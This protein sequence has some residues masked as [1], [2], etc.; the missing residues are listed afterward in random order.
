MT[1]GESAPAVAESCVGLPLQSTETVTDRWPM[2]DGGPTL[3]DLVPA[4]PRQLTMTSPLLTPLQAG[5]LHLKNRVVMAP[6]TRVRAGKTHVPNALMA[7]YYAQRASAGL[8]MTE[9][10]MV[11]ADA[12]AFIAEGGIFDEATAAGWKDVADAVHARGGQIIMQIWHPGRA[13][14]SANNR[15]VQSVSATTKPIR[16]DTIQTPTGK[17]PYQAPR[18]LRTDEM[19]GIVELFRSGAERA[20]AAGFDGVQI[21]GAHG[22]LIDQFLRDGVNDRSDA[23]GG[24]L[25]NRARLLLEV[26]DAAIGVFGAG[27]VALRISPI[28]PFNDML[29]SNPSAL[30]A[31][32]AQQMSARH[33]AFLEIRHDQHDRPEEI[34]LAKIARDNFVGVMMLNGGFNQASGEAAVASGRADA[35]VYGRLIIANPDLVERF[36]RHAPL[37]PLDPTTLYAPGPEGYTDYPALAA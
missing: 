4:I 15:G 21:H 9:C 25:E 10:T 29:D 5:D 13:A 35:I 2:F 36:A 28:V 32:V 27:R 37:N 33:I 6:L 34:A 12:T 7:E 24:S 8:V 22:Y 1:A 19:P 31:Y 26:V 16:N 3:A 14:H 18:A 17:Q 11:A 20:Q 30:V 23:Y